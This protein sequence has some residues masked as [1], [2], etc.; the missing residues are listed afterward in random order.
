M[1]I[2]F[3]WRDRV[4]FDEDYTS[5]ELHLLIWNG[6]P[7]LI[8]GMKMDARTQSSGVFRYLNYETSQSGDLRL[9]SLPLVKPNSQ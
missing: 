8:T 9:I 5:G 3:P 2:N 6:S 1:T 7:V 4:E